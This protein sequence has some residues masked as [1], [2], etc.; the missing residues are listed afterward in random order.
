MLKRY[1]DALMQRFD[2][3]AYKGFAFIEWWELNA[4]YDMDRISK[5]VWRDLQARFVEVANDEKADLY[6][7]EATGGLL[8]VH[9]DALAKISSDGAKTSV[10]N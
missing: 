10:Q 1:E 3:V 4:W 9:S 5:N 2:A 6:V 7:Y 8:L